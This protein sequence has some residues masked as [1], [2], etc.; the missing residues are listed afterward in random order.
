MRVKR[1]FA[2][3]TMRLRYSAVLLDLLLM[4]AAGCGPNAASTQSAKP[5]TGEWFSERA[6]E[7]GL[8]FVHFNGMSGKYFYPELMAP[9]VALFDYDNDGDLDV[10]VVQSGMLGKTPLS[11]AQPQPRDPALKSRLFRNDLTSSGQLHFTDV[12]DA[13]GID[14]QGY[15]MGVA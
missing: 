9:G 8:D 12:T 14:A 15:G 5:D 6:H 7:A 13:S 2:W 10:F 3:Y 4:A 11:E 1:L